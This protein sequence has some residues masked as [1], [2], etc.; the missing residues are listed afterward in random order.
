MGSLE[1]GGFQGEQSSRLPKCM[2]VV[3]VERRVGAGD[4]HVAGCAKESTLGDLRCEC[5]PDVRC[6]ATRSWSKNE[7]VTLIVSSFRVMVGGVHKMVYCGG[8]KCQIVMST[9]SRLKAR[10]SASACI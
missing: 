7:V 2:S 5:P 3:V 8:A 1:C 4:A 9:S 10:G 6:G